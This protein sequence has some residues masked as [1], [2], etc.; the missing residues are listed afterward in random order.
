[1]I[2]VP[3]YARSD[4]NRHSVVVKRGRC[5]L[6]FLKLLQVFGTQILKKNPEARNKTEHLLVFLGGVLS[7]YVKLL[8]VHSKIMCQL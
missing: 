2:S 5:V 6:N 8:V 1:M 4:S 7:L 3:S